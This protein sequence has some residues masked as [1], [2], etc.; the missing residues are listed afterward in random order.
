[1][2]SVQLSGKLC[3]GYEIRFSKEGKP[4][5][6]GSLA[7]WNSFTK[8][9]EFFRFTAFGKNAERMKDWCFDHAWMELKGELGT[10]KWTDKNGQNRNDIGIRVDRFQIIRNDFVAKD[11]NQFTK[12]DDGA[13]RP[14][15]DLPTEDGEDLP[16]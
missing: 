11:P 13:G 10:S 9:S 6:T 15:N 1:M 16:F 7:I 8:E 5:F 4:I 12:E 14:E 2:N 3:R